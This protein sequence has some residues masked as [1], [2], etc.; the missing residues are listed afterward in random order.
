MP[1]CSGGRGTSVVAGVGRG[2]ERTGASGVADIGK[3]VAGGGGHSTRRERSKLVKE[4]CKCRG[5]G[6]GSMGG[7]RIS[8][9]GGAGD[10]LHAFMEVEHRVDIICNS[11]IGGVEDS[12]IREGRGVG[13]HGATEGSQCGR[14]VTR[15]GY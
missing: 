4:G 9:N 7:R 11:G 3:G 13:R 1:S 8:D 14:M 15:R 12:N 6:G 10:D 2:A 5:R